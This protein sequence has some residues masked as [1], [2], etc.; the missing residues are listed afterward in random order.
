[1]FIQTTDYN[2]FRIS[3][4]SNSKNVNL[5]LHSNK[6]YDSFRV[7]THSTHDCGF[8]ITPGN[9]LINLFNNS[10]VKGLGKEAIRAAI[11]LGADNLNCFD[12][13]LVSIYNSMGFIETSRVTFNPNFAPYN[14]N[15]AMGTPDVVFLKLPLKV[16]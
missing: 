9:E 16:S 3:L 8:A 10:R 11:E 5:E 6:E 14:W 2:N 15:N 1:M 4:K 7:Y 13:P 12:G